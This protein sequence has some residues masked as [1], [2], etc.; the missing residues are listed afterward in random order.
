MKLTRRNALSATAIGVFMAANPVNALTSSRDA[1]LFAGC[2]PK[3]SSGGWRRPTDWPAL[4]TLATTDE[5]FVGLYAVYNDSSNFIA[6]T[7]QG[8]FTVNW[9]DG[10]APVNYSS[11]AT[12]LYNYSYS[13]SGLGPLTSEGYKTAIVT[14]T[15]QGGSHLTSFSLQVKHTQS[16]LKSY[17]PPWLD[18][19][20][21]GANLTSFSVGGSTITVGLLQRATI[22]TVGSITSFTNMFQYCYSLQSVPL[23]NTAAGINFSNMFEYCYSLQS[24]PLF[25]TA[26]GTNF[27]SMFYACY[28]LQSVPLFNTAAGANFTSM[29]YDCFSLQSVPLFNT[30]AGTNF[31]NM[32]QYCYS[33]GLGTLSGTKYSISYDSCK[34]GSAELIAILN[35]LGTAAGAQTVTITNNWGDDGDAPLVTAIAGAVSKGWTVAS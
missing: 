19:S 14:V 7:A 33:L 4:P 31:T 35:A 13:A 1:V 15:P 27:T 6:L 12:A 20:L 34:L 23:F 25:N 30:A 18:I 28:S 2:P 3:S 17:V 9:G 8:A 16:G 21:N 26:A 10:S 5:K 29:F 32:F 11:G 22:G 24:V